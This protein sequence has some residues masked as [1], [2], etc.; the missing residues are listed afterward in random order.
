MVYV[1][2]NG[3]VFLHTCFQKLKQ[4]NSHRLRLRISSSAFKHT[5]KSIETARYVRPKIYQ[6]QPCPWEGKRER[7]ADIEG[8]I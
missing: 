1:S 6:V 3:R 8:R 7:V 5:R 4:H 2:M